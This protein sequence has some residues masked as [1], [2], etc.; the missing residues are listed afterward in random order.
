[1]RFSPLLLTITAFSQAA[2]ADDDVF[3]LGVIEVNGK[4]EQEQPSDKETYGRGH[5]AQQP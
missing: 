2:P 5:S 4:V 3:N 1:M